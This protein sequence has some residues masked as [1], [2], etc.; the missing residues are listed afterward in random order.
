VDEVFWEY[1]FLERGKIREKR[2]RWEMER[3][4]YPSDLSDE[5]WVSWLIGSSV[6]NSGVIFAVLGVQN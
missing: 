4:A 5:E 3:T 2:R 1:G 6:P